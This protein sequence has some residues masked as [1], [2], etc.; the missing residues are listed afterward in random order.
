MPVPRRAA[1]NPKPLGAALFLIVVCTLP[2]AARVRSVRSGSS[3]APGNH[4]QSSQLV[5]A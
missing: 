2:G 5:R 1:I 4:P 3:E